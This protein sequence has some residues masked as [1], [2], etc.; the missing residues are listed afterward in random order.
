[1][2]VVLIV[3]LLM[4]IADLLRRDSILR[5]LFSTGPASRQEQ[6]IEGVRRTIS[7]AG[8]AGSTR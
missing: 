6:L 8:C 4:V 7:T 3:L 2:A 1:M 5:S